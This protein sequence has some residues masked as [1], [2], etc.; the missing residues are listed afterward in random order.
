MFRAFSRAYTQ[1]VD[2]VEKVACS[3]G[4]QRSKKTALRL[5]N[6][7]DTRLNVAFKLDDHFRSKT[8][9]NSAQL[10][11]TLRTPPFFLFFFFFLDSYSLFEDGDHL[12][13]TFKESRFPESFIQLL[14]QASICK[15]NGRVFINYV[16]T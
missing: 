16:V 10:P 8:P 1:Q 13:S 9:L 12:F 4:G 14:N 7:F 2:Q 5:N 11:H 6:S 15:H 3:V